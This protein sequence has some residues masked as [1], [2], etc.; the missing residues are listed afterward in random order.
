MKKAGLFFVSLTLCLLFLSACNPTPQQP[1][2]ISLEEGIAGMTQFFVDA[3]F[4]P[5]LSQRDMKLQMEK[6]SYEGKPIEEQVMGY[7]YDGLSGGGFSAMGDLFGFVNDYNRPQD[8][9]KA[10]YKNYFYTTVPLDGLIL[11]L[12]IA[13]GDPIEIVCEKTGVPM[14]TS[15]QTKSVYQ[16]GQVTVTLSFNET[17]EDKNYVLSESSYRYVLKYER[18]YESTRASGKPVTVT[19]TMTF[20]FKGEGD[21]LSCFYIAVNENYKP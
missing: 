6:Y 8:S 10:D 5:G 19:E 15:S 18:L 1:V 20:F 13:L 17:P 11:P 21:S 7:H 4:V 14:L 3:N 16:S 9:E 2:P 12:G